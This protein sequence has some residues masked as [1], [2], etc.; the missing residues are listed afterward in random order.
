MSQM[1]YYQLSNSSRGCYPKVSSSPNSTINSERN[2][3]MLQRN[4]DNKVCNV[5]ETLL[6]SSLR[7]YE[8]ILATADLIPEILSSIMH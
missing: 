6:L 8:N 5:G 2:V 7:R 4:V 3:L 1:N